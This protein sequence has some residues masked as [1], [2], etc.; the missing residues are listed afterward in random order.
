M[1]KLISHAP[2]F[3]VPDIA[4]AV[5]YYESTLGF[6]ANYVVG[7]LFAICVRDGLSIM[8]RRVAEPAKIA[9]NE[10]QGGTWDVFFWIDDA[11]GLHAE[12][13]GRGATV[14][15]GPLV[16]EEYQMLEFAVRDLNGY[17]LGFGQAL[18]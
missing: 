16:Q 15:Y 6:K 13:E 11:K 8:L 3:P 7:D 18:K 2:Y 4:K 14:V 5:A 12:L 1:P 9:P 17:V 10:A